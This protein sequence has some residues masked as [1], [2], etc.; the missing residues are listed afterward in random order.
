MEYDSSRLV[1]AVEDV[2][3]ELATHSDKLDEIAAGVNELADALWD[4]NYT[5]MPAHRKLWYR[6]RGWRQRR[7]QARNDRTRQVQLGV[8]ARADDV[9]ATNT[10]FVQ[11]ANAA[12]EAD[13][14][15]RIKDYYSG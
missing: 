15:D 3:D 5:L 12:R 1:A 10:Y 13:K 9:L 14:A 2:R 6:I 8:H 4:I 11:A 7:Q